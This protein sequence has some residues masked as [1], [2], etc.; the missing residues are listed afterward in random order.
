MPA[1]SFTGR[2]SLEE[3]I[4]ERRSLRTYAP[5]TISLQEVSQLLWAAQGITSPDGKRSA[6][7]AGAL[8][9]LEVFLLAGEVA[10]LAPGV[11]HYVA[12]DHVL[13]LHRPGDHREVLYH[14]A[15]SQSAV[16]EAPAVLVIVALYERSTLK[17]GQRGVQYTHIEAGCVAQNVALQAES[18]GLG[19]V[20]IGAFEETRTR[21]ALGL[22]ESQVPLG[23][24]PVGRQ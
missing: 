9:P 19:T 10:G 4:L 5:G 17:Y 14:A 24:M 13:E 1:P 12:L 21:D 6:P 11:Y 8:Y 15:L 22:Q 23:L 18:L 16:R 7:S 20:F 3:A 2:V